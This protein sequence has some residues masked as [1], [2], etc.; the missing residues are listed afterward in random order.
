MA[1]M[2]S[3]LVDLK[4]RYVRTTKNKL[5]EEMTTKIAEETV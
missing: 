4:K 5:I 3:P 2:N 1:R